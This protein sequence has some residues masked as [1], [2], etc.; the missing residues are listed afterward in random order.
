MNTQSMMIYFCIACGFILALIPHILW[1]I[2]WIISR[3]TNTQIPYR[4]FGRYSYGG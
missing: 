2:S 1:G 4:F 3:F